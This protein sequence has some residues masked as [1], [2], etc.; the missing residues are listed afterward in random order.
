MSTPTETTK[1][2]SPSYQSLTKRDQ[3]K[4][5]LGLVPQRVR[6][7]L[8]LIRFEKV[9]LRGS[10]YNFVLTS[11]FKPTGTILMFWP[12]G[13]PA[14][15]QTS[16]TMLSEPRQR[17]VSPWPLAQSAFP[18]RN[19]FQGFCNAFSVLGSSVALHVL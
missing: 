14:V 16:R 1:L 5:P 6:P 11:V 15:S 17:G 7:Y 8:E 9:C 13:A 18:C 2:F 19:T 4:F 10:D 3:L 12:F